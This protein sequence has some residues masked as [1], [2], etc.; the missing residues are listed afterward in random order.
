MKYPLMGRA[1]IFNDVP[2][3]AARISTPGKLNAGL[4]GLVKLNRPTYCILVS[5]GLTHSPETGR[6]D[7]ALHTIAVSKKTMIAIFFLIMFRF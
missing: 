5:E 4:S 7:D 2:L 6:V 1:I 3:K